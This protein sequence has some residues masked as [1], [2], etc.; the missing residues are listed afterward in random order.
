MTRYLGTSVKRVEDPRFLRGLGKYVANLTLPN[1]AYAAVKRS[2]LAHAKIRGIDTTRAKALDGVIAVFTGEDLLE[3]TGGFK[4]GSLPCGFQ[5]PNLNMPPHNPL[6]VDKVRHV[7]DGIAVVVA[8]SPYIAEDALDLIEVDLDPLPAVVDARGA[9]ADGA[10]LVHDS[11]EQNLAFHWPL[12]DEEAVN[13]ALSKSD[14]VVELEFINQRL[15]ANA[16]E[17]RAAAAEWDP[18]TESLTVWT[19]SQNPHTIRLL[20]GAFTLGIPEHKIRVISP[21]VGGGFGSKIFHYPEEVIVPFAARAVGRPVKWVATRSE[22]YVTDAQGR[23]HVTKAK[24]GVNNDGTMTALH[25]TTWANMGAYLSTFGPLIPTALYITLFSGVYKTPVIF[26]EAYGTFTHTVPVD[27]YRGAGR[28]EASYLVETMVD[29][30]ARKLGMDP[31]ELRR[32]NLIPTDAFPY[33]TP[34]AL[35]YDS[36]NYQ[37][38]F[39]KIEELS[40]YE[41]LRKEQE[42]ARAEGRLVGVGF[43]S[44]IEASGPAPSAVAVGLGAAIGLFESGAIRVHPTG[45]V[46]VLTGSH[47]HGQGHETTFAQIVAD[48]FGIDIADVD[49]VHGDTGRVQY[50]IGTYGSRSAAIGGSAL[51]KSAEKI[52]EKLKQIAAHQL[53]ASVEDMVYDQDEGTISVAGS[54]DMVK[55]FAELAF[56]SVLANN[57]PEGM[58]PGLEESSFYDPANFTFPASA[59]VAKVEI[60]PKTGEVDLQS[61]AAVDDVGNVINPM[62]VEGQ[63]LGGIVQGVGQALWEN[64]IYDEDGQLLS[65]SML[66]YAMPRADGF[67]SIALDRIETPSPHNPLGVKGAGEMGTIAATAAVSSAVLDALAPLGVRHLNMPLTAEKIHQ[68]IAAAGNG[69][70]E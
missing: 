11:A 5:V 61:Y 28:P 40:G 70:G 30:A 58:E 14:H 67:P 52:R 47:S 17:P 50:G 45:K 53:E 19:T 48:Q 42:A 64:G 46:T 29:L 62:I 24:L 54:P 36:G 39:E 37:A 15:I 27:A 69:G 13:E 23:D 20:L 12:G 38:L 41:S 66:S 16:M 56:A 33:Q 65:G 1:M 6:A 18:A 59:H 44:C 49:I 3:G 35:M 57:L 26:G 34:V 55:T 32:K 60:D 8:E 22:S 25:V 10:P 43:A 51:V 63:I 4:C 2:P 9:M 68:A 31:V 7:G 21:D